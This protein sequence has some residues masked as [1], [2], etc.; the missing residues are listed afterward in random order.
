[1]DPGEPWELVFPGLGRCCTW[2]LGGT[3]APHL[4]SGNEGHPGWR[5]GARVFF[6]GL[7]QDGR[8]QGAV[9]SSR[10]P[11]KPA[12]RVKGLKPCD[13]HPAWGTELPRG[14]CFLAVNGCVSPGGGG[15]THPALFHTD[16]G[17]LL[18]PLGTTQR[19]F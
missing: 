14:F 4:H 16:Q 17:A 10:V 6:L 11:G 3:T 19:L 8:S 13:P 5:P 18:P 2:P 7:P 15:T 9:T 12:L 1:M